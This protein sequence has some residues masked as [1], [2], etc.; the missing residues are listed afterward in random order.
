[1]W[2]A[3]NVF[4]T[5]GLHSEQVV[6]TNVMRGMRARWATVPL[7]TRL[8]LLA[9]LGALGAAGVGYLTS[10]NEYAEPIGLAVVTRVVLVMTLVLTGVYALTNRLQARMGSLL[11]AVG[12]YAVAWLLNGSAAPLAFTIGVLAA[13]IAPIVF[14]ALLLSHPQ[15]R[16]RSRADRRVLSVAWRTIVP[17]WLLLMLISPRAPLS[18]PLMRCGIHCPRNL[19]FTGVRPEALE[20]VLTVATFALW[21]G[22]SC[23][24]AAL[25]VRRWR[26]ASPLQRSALAPVLLAAVLIPVLLSAYLVFRQTG[27]SGGRLVGAAYISVAIAVP[28]TILT[29]LGRERLY[30]AGALTRFLRQ[31]AESPAADPE[32][33]MAAS[34]GDP[35]LRIAYRR[36]NV[37]SYVSLNGT[38]VTITTSD[39]GRAVTYV[40]R[41]QDPVAAVSYSSALRD[42]ERF[43]EAAASVA[44]MRLE[45]AQ[46]EADLRASTADLNASRVRL[47]EAAHEERRRIERDLHD[48]VQQQLVGL[49]IKLGMAA[50]T[51]NAQPQVAEEMLSQVEAEIDEVLATLRNLA[52]GIYPALLGER[53]VTAALTA[54]A[55]RLPIAATV[56]G[57]DIGRYPEEVEV[58]VYFCCLEALQNVVKHGGQSATAHVHLWRQNG[59]LCFEVRDTGHGFDCASVDG[60]TGLANMRDRV[61][62]IGGTLS[63]RSRSGIGTSVT[64]TAPARLLATSAGAAS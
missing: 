54:A 32:A 37:D 47:V 1:M 3:P 7:G 29:G 40:E 33:L 46:L 25:L 61:E 43:I 52:R 64:G 11:V 58:A 13:G 34:L 2:T 60:G 55:Q 6:P 51:L 57:A 21:L 10:L 14:A 27:L 36:P 30:V 22:I 42:Q 35:T 20:T 56:K 28:L 50:D 31:L 53:G 15:G 38:P 23:A 49:R 17:V 62:A 19:L 8:T 26:A 4:R 9:A 63:V 45:G 24:A 44:L 5:A 59:D 48:T 16:L 39:P 41:D 18:S 12:L